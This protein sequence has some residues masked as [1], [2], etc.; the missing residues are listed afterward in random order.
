LENVCFKRI[1]KKRPVG[2][3][4][5]LLFITLFF[6]F[7]LFAKT[8]TL[9]SGEVVEGK[10]LKKTGE[11]I[12]VDHGG[13]LIKLYQLD[14]VKN[15]DGKTTFAA[16]DKFSLYYTIALILLIIVA[17]ILLNFF[18]LFVWEAYP[19]IG[20]FSFSVRNVSIKTRILSFLVFTGC[21]PLPGWN[22]LYCMIAF[23]L[24]IFGKK[25]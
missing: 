21:L 7:S 10:I 5:I 2:I 22:K 16:M 17:P 12:K 14:E 20:W 6:S 13:G 24:L 23:C 9:N 3:T 1:M 25:E 11:Y 15:I 8:I 19:G 18:C 4:L